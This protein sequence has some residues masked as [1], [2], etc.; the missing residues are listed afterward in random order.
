MNADNDTHC[1]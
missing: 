1:L